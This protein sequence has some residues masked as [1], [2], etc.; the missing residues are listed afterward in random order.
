MFLNIESLHHTINITTYLYVYDK[1]YYMYI[2]NIYEAQM[3]VK[4]IIYSTTTETEK[5]SS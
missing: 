1:M 4:Y 2:I 3:N 5:M